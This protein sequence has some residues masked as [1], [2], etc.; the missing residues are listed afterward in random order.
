MDKTYF[1]MIKLLLFFVSIGLLFWF[2]LCNP[3]FSLGFILGMLHKR[4]LEEVT[5]VINY[6]IKDDLDD[7]L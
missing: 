5:A 6:I 3:V 7:V 1:E 2:M 4:I